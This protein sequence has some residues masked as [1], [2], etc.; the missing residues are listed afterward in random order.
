MH[1]AYVYTKNITKF[2]PPRWY[3]YLLWPMDYMSV[4]YR[5]VT[6]FPKNNYIFGMLLALRNIGMVK[7]LNRTRFDLSLRLLVL[8][9]IFLY[10]LNKDINSCIS[11]WFI[12][13]SEPLPNYIIIPIFL[14]LLWYDVFCFE[15]LLLYGSF[16]QGNHSWQV[17]YL[18]KRARNVQCFFISWHRHVYHRG[19]SCLFVYSFIFTCPHRMTC[20]GFE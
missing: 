3:Q 2:C 18:Q 17:D 4:D 19:Y 15:T 14:K 13:V 10:M 11:Q 5:I 12:T 8:N 16:V 9:E 7:T 1:W 6:N 20:V